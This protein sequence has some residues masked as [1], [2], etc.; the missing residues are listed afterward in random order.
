MNRLLIPVSKKLQLGLH[1]DDLLLLLLW[2]NGYRPCLWTV[3]LVALIDVHHWFFLIVLLRR[4]IDRLLQL[5]LDRVLHI[6]HVVVVEVDHADIFTSIVADLLHLEVVGV[7]VFLNG[8]GSSTA[9]P[10]HQRSSSI[11]GWFEV[12]HCLAHHDAVQRP[13]RHCLCDFFCPDH[14]LVGKIVVLRHLEPCLR[15]ALHQPT[16]DVDL[17]VGHGFRHLHE[18]EEVLLRLLLVDGHVKD[19]TVWS[20]KPQRNQI[21]LPLILHH[22]YA[23]ISIKTQE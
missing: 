17:V 2:T 19:A 10:Y 1:V 22:R 20:K 12:P 14:N 16:I 11:V 9:Q 18:L 8:I 5:V 21:W 7:L 15:R 23:I 3:S 6:V 13:L 4:S